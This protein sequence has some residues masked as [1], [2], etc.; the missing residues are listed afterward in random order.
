QLVIGSGEG[1]LQADVRV[2]GELIDVGANIQEAEAAGRMALAVQGN[3]IDGQTAVGGVG[4]DE[5]ARPVDAE[6]EIECHLGLNVEG[7]L[8]GDVADAETEAGVESGLA[9][10]SL[11]QLQGDTGQVRLAGDGG[12]RALQGILQIRERVD[13]CA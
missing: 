11:G 12:P 4:V 3:V 5:E 1:Q 9:V 7:S 2:D 10:Q 6:S 8:K 13:S